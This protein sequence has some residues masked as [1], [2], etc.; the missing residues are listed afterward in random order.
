VGH[1][2]DQKEEAGMFHPFEDLRRIMEARG[3]PVE[4]E[5]LAADETP[6]ASEEDVF[7][8]AMSRVRE[9]RE[10]R[11]L[12]LPQRKP[13]QVCR[14]QP[15]DG[16]ALKMLE[17]LVRGVGSVRLRDTQEY[18]EWVNPLYLKQIAQDL[19]RGRFSVKDF[20]DLHGFTLDEA[21][22]EVEHFLGESLKKGY[23]CVKIIHGR[24]LRSPAGPVLKKSVADWLSRRHRKNVIAFVTARQC[25]GGLGALYVLLR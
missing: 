22:V 7:R 10:F 24:G 21:E 8:E 12:S 13:R 3:I 25:D 20:L 11:R 2:K 9:I 15:G 4:S 17:E 1:R 16:D 6:P 18:V 19:H 14:K 23:R 5:P